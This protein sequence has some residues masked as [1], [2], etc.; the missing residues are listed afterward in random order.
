M[1]QG[2]LDK[3][4]GAYHLNAVDEVTQFE[5]I[6]TV[7]KISERYLVP[8]LEQL[9]DTFPFKVL[10][11]HTDNGSEYINK[12]VAELLE[13][14]LIEFTKSRSRQSNDNALAESKNGAVVRKLFGYSHIPQRFAPL[15]NDFNQQYLNPYLNFHRP[16]FFPE[17]RT[18]DQGKQHKVYR[19]EKMMTPYDKLK[20]LPNAKD[21]LKPGISFAILD[22]LAHQIS[23]NQAADRLQKA[24]QKLFKTIHGRTLK[25]G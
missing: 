6:C 21:Y 24:R 17:T 25:T 20:S 23:D 16:C 9:L 15:I 5:V 3:Q 19:Y 2:D 8:I 10:G 7:E 14:L 22:Q 18:D 4:K 13:K 12:R 11:F 1:H